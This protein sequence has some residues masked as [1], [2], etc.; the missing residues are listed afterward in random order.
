MGQPQVKDR[1]LA[2]MKKLTWKSLLWWCLAIIVISLLMRWS[3]TVVIVTNVDAAQQDKLDT[4]IEALARCESSGNPG[5]LNADDGGSASY[6]LLQFKLDTF[7]RYSRKLGLYS[8]AEDAEIANLVN[9]PVLQKELARAMI[10]DDS[11][12]WRNWYN[13]TTGANGVKAIGLPPKQ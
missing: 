1:C 10:L 6:G 7:R 12:A 13:C 11:S 8:A 9:D 2:I 4:W 5:A 3:R